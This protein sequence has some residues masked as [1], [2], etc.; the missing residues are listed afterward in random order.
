[1]KR[2]KVQ[3]MGKALVSL[4]ILSAAIGVLVSFGA[5]KE[6]AAKD[7]EVRTLTLTTI[8]SEG[9]EL[10]ET[11]KFFTN[12][13]EKRTQGKIKFAIF[14]GASLVPFRRFLSSVDKG[15]VDSAFAVPT[16]EISLWPIT[17]AVYLFGAP[18]LTYE[19]WR[20]IHDPIRDILN[21]NININV[22]IVSMPHVTNYALYSRKPLRGKAVDFKGLLIRGP[23][24]GLDASIKT[25]GGAPV[26]MAASETTMAL[27]RGTI[28]AAVNIYFRYMLDKHYQFAPYFM[29]IPKG[30]ST[31]SQYFIVNK[32]VWNSLAA[33]IKKIFLQ[34]GTDVVAFTN[35]R[36]AASD[37]KI[38]TE[39]LPKLGITPIIMSESENKLF[40]Q[41]LKP[42]WDEYI[43]KLGE[44]AD[45]IA[46]LIGVR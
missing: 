46:E 5:S 16:Y 18:N 30:S 45:R 44:P 40:L 27:E 13:I 17:D 43:A 24:G 35:D 20:T 8:Y 19:K 1:M 41:M 29:E 7:P 14:P 38:V 3:E 34:V 4:C 6:V 11:V 22:M 33:D 23:G 39:D 15:V 37:K 21:K 10:Y 28:D 31:V 42:L 2:V 12:E 32:G 9:Q 26:F 36:S 25:L